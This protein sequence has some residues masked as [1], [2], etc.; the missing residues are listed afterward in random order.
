MTS[1]PEFL[2]K[3]DYRQLQFCRD[4]CEARIKAIE[5]EEKKV[6]WAV[7]DGQINY[8]WYRTEDYLKAVEGLAREAEER[9]KQEDKSNPEPRNWLNFSIRGQRLPVSEY[10][11]L[12]ADGQW[13]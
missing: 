8:G 4:E 12:F 5:E 7:T 10:E 1:T 2:N 11:A 13:G 6:A 9:W 3:L